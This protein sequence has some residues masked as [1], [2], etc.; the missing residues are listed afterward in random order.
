MSRQLATGPEPVRRIEIAIELRRPGAAPQ[1]LA[2]VGELDAAQ[3]VE[4]AAFGVQDLAEQ[5]PADHVEDHHLH[6]VVVAVLHHH[7]VLPVLLGRLDHRPAVVDRHRRRH[8]G[9][10]VLPVLHRRQHDRHVPFPRRGVVDEIE[11]LGL[12]EPLEV[13]RAAVVDGRRGMPG[14]GDLLGRPFGPLGADVAD[15]GDAA[16]RDLQQV[17]N[18]A[19]ALAADPDIANPYQ[20]DRGAASGAAAGSCAASARSVDRA[21]AA[22]SVPPSRSRSRR[23]RSS[24]L[25]AS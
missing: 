7:A 21:L 17:P 16:A 1:P 2:L 12:A 11:R 20:V 3:V 8:F 14:R 6:A 5:R 4:V 23:F 18:V 24:M 13:A 15:R 19:A 10:G 9:G 25:E 22:S